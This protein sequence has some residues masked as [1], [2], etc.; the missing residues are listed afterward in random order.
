MPGKGSAWQEQHVTVTDQTGTRHDTIYIQ[1]NGDFHSAQYYQPDSVGNEIIPDGSL[2]E[3]NP[4]V[5]C[6]EQSV[7]AWAVANYPNRVQ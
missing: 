7:L 5:A 4:A 3:T 1:C 2:S 6:D